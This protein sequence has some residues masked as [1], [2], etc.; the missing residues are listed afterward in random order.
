MLIVAILRLE[1][2]DVLRKEPSPKCQ[3]PK[4]GAGAVLNRYRTV[5]IVF[6]PCYDVVLS[7]I[8]QEG[9]IVLVLI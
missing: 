2:Y 6:A 7:H 8:E 3:A 9:R 1:A 5:I 4:P